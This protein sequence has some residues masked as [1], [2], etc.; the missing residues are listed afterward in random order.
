MSAKF[1]PQSFY[2]SLREVQLFITGEMAFGELSQLTVEASAKNHEEQVHK[3]IPMWKRYYLS[4][5][6]IERLTRPKSPLPTSDAQKLLSELWPVEGEVL[7]LEKEQI[8]YNLEEFSEYCANAKDDAL[9]DVLTFSTIPAVF[10]FFVLETQ[11]GKLLRF[12]ER[13]KT[14]F[15]NFLKF[16]RALF[17]SPHFVKFVN[18]TI[19]PL[20][21][22]ALNEKRNY[23]GMLAK[24]NENW[25][26]KKAQIPLFIKQ[27]LSAL[28]PDEAKRVLRVCFWEPFLRTP[29]RFL[30]CN[31]YDAASIDVFS[32]KNCVDNV[33]FESNLDDVYLDMFISKEGGIFDGGAALSLGEISMTDENTNGSGFYE[34]VFSPLDKQVFQKKSILGHKWD[35]TPEAFKLFFVAFSDE[36]KPQGPSSI[37]NQTMVTPGETIAYYLRQ[38]LKSAPLLRQNVR[39]SAEKTPAEIVKDALV[40]QA[41]LKSR[42]KQQYLFSEIEAGLSGGLDWESVFKRMRVVHQEQ[43]EEMA[44]I[45]KL[46]RA[47]KRCYNSV[48]ELMS[49]VQRYSCLAIVAR[50]Q[51]S[52]PTFG[53]IME[54]S[55]ASIIQVMQNDYKPKGV[56]GEVQLLVFYYIL[57]ANMNYRW[58]RTRQ[59]HLTTYDV[60]AQQYLQWRGREGLEEILKSFDIVVDDI[61]AFRDFDEVVKEL[62]GIFC[63]EGAPLEKLNDFLR[64][65]D[66]IDY[67]AQQTFPRLCFDDEDMRARMRAAIGVY[68]NPTRIVSMYKYMAHMNELCQKDTCL[69][70]EQKRT[71]AKFQKFVE[72]VLQ[73]M[74]GDLSVILD[75]Q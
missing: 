61:N 5:L 74:P 4:Q 12:F 8:P 41:D 58:Y 59:V 72:H 31:I 3:A 57:S 24:I 10:K 50:S 13:Q 63:T 15:D 73:G 23:S 48:A 69:T 68:A 7:E 27:V 42:S 1:D 62:Q 66:K 32:V 45:E 53:K 20:L 38:M 19:Y 34:R 60:F 40:Y 18:D 16:C 22:P 54:G 52:V 43:F 65:F 26:E 28:S 49:E 67:I 56:K 30:G 70:F 47:I 33:S 39:I 51:M 44:K 46:G 71:F 35:I 37:V 25:Q 6:V 9:I 21:Q 2:D 36:F 14:N 55:V 29:Q 64:V 75:M 11:R 17:V